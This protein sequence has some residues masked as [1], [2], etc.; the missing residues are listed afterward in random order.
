MHTAAAAVARSRQLFDG[1][2]TRPLA[3]RLE[4]LR[5]LRRMLSDRGEDFAAATWASTGANRS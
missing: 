4:Q 1:G 5:N 3:W 2:T